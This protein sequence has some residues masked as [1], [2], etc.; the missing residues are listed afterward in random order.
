MRSDVGMFSPQLMDRLP[1]VFWIFNPKENQL[2]YISKAYE[3][4]W[5]R[6][7]ASAYQNPTS[8]LEAVHPADFLKAKAMF[9]KQ[10]RGK[11]TREVFRVIRKDGSVRWVRDQCLNLDPRRSRDGRLFGLVE[12]ITDLFDGIPQRYGR[13]RLNSDLLSAGIAHDINNV[14]TAVL[15]NGEMLLKAESTSEGRRRAD[16]I[17]RA[18]VVGRTLTKA[19]IDSTRFGTLRAEEVDLNALVLKM[20]EVLI[21]LIGKA[22]RLRIETC[23][24]NPVVRAHPAFMERAV[25]NLVANARDAMPQGGEMTISTRRTEDGEWDSQKRLR[26][27]PSPRF[28]VVSVTD[29]GC[30]IGDADRNKIFEPFFTTKQ[31]GHGT[32]LG[33]Y[34][35]KCIVERFRGHIRIDSSKNH[36]TS[37]RLYFRE[38]QEKR[39]DETEGRLWLGS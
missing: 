33:L 15:G 8:F 12:D 37:V 31:D 5:G 22:I 19:L 25:L 36:G 13:A 35:V 1:F 21:D 11:P 29:T 17:V 6:S 30:G 26:F 27:G 32:G 3:S 20:Q 16:A 2:I 38:G 24:G 9:K 10:L 4:I 14:L 34:I 7:R 39:R 28:M 23:P 18:A